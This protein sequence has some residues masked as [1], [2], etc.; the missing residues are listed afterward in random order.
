M[1]LASGKSGRPDN[2]PASL[3]FSAS[4]K[5]GGRA[6]VVLPTIMPSTR[7]ER[8]MPTTS[9]RSGNDRSGAIFSSTG[10]GPACGATRSR[11]S[12]TR[13]KRSSSMAACCSCVEP[14]VLGE[15]M[16]TVT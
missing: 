12:I 13:A 8:A 9:S 3:A 15:E 1:R 2:P 6:T 10:V 16:L 14:G 5:L 7:R 11:A 4:R